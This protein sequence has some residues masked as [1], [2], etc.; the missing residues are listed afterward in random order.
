MKKTE[1]FFRVK[2]R[3]F[4]YG[5]TCHVIITNAIRRSVNTM[6]ESEIDGMAQ[7]WKDE[8]CRVISRS[9]YEV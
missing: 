5:E 3:Y 6:T 7:A 8:G 9:D 4:V 2:K 1:R